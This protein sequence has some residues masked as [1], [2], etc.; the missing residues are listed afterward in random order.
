MRNRIVCLALAILPAGL[1]TSSPPA[2]I[3]REVAADAGLNVQHFT[4]ATGDYFM[5]EIMG[6]GAAL[7]DYDNDG[8]LDVYV[9]QGTAL[10]ENRKFLFPPR[11]GSPPGNRL[12][13]NM[14]A[15]T[16]KLHFV[17]VTERARVGHESYGMGA[18]TGD[19]DNDGFMDLYVTTFGHNVLYHNNRDGTFADVTSEANAD[20]PRWSTSAAFL[21]YDK[22][23]Y[24][25]LFVGNYV[26]FTVTGNKRCYAPTGERDYCTPV[27]YKAVPSRLFHNL[28]NGRFADVTDASGIGSAY[29]PA[30]GVV[31]ADF[32]GDGR[33]DIYV[34]N[35]TAANR[36]WLNQGDGTFRES[37][38][39]AGMAY[40]ADGLTKAGMGVAAEEIDDHGTL[41]V[42]VTNLTREGATVFRGD[43]KGQFEDVSVQYGLAAP[44]FAFTG[45]GTQWLDYDND[46]L[47][48]L[49]IANGGVS[50]SES[51]RGAPYPY[52]QRNLLFHNE[53]KGR[54][55]QETGG[56]AGPAFQRLEVGRG[57]AVG[58]IDNDGAVDILVTNNN[59]PVRLL[60]NDI[61]P[62]QHWIEVRLEGVKSNRFGIGARVALLRDGEE[63]VWRRVHTDSS[64]LSASDVRVHFGLGKSSDVRALIVRWPDGSEESWDGIRPDKVVVLR[65]GSGKSR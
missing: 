56:I 16:G 7:F 21:D 27:A 57:A 62:R 60:H 20:D 45:F 65:Q 33:A 36:L 29:G 32:N 47:L 46:G 64:Y 48:D 40:N 1:V 35:D 34:A 52:G 53:G 12:F 25:D 6:S 13:R 63:P 38:L 39:E 28:G 4:G 49:F 10:G 54:A 5:P 61:V 2:P 55:F 58:D 44:T 51:M 9:I 8:D 18:A 3:F 26:D 19:Y 50:I 24:L 22:D 17:D 23:G 37:G 15:E 42:V 30:L 41:A 59:G 11:P 31:S 43:G 14:V